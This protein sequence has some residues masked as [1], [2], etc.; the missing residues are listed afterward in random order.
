MAPP[1]AQKATRP[2]VAGTPAPARP[3]AKETPVPVPKPGSMP[4]LPNSAPQTTPVARSL[5]NDA[6]ALAPAPAPGVPAFSV[7]APG[8]AS[9][10]DVT[11]GPLRDGRIR[12]PV[13][14]KLKGKTDGS[15]G[16][17]SVMHMDVGVKGEATERDAQAKRTSESTAL[18]A[19]RA[20]ENGYVALRR[21]RF[22]HI[23]DEP[24]DEP[25][26]PPP[27][28]KPYVPP[29]PPPAVLAT[30]STRRTT[31]NAAETKAEQARLLTL[32]RSLHP[33]L[34]VDQMCKA[35]A[36]FGGIP[37]APPPADGCFPQSAEANGP[38]SL[39]VGWVAEI[40]PKLG[41]NT[42][43]REPSPARQLDGPP[44]P[45]KR[46]RGRPKGS[47]ATKARKDKGIKKGPLK[48]LAT[49]SEPPPP[50]PPPPM[51]GDESWVDVDDTVV[52]G[53]VGGDADD[54]DDANVLLLAR[55][56][57]PSPRQLPT[58]EGASQ[59]AAGQELINQATN[60]VNRA[61]LLGSDAVNSSPAGTKKRGRPKG[62]KNRPRLPD[63]APGESVNSS[64]PPSQVSPPDRAP[65]PVPSALESSQ[66]I[67]GLP[68]FTPTLPTPVK[69]TN[70]VKGVSSRQP[71]GAVVEAPRMRETPVPVPVPNGQ[72]GYTQPVA[73]QQPAHRPP[74]VSAMPGIQ[75]P[76]APRATSPGQDN[77]SLTAQKRKRNGEKEPT[78]APSGGSITSS[79]VVP[80]SPGNQTARATLGYSKVQNP[81]PAKRQKKAP[82]VKAPPEQSNAYFLEP[83]E[84]PAAVHENNTPSITPSSRPGPTQNLEA[85]R[86]PEPPQRQPSPPPDPAMASPQSPHH[87]HFEVQSPTMENYEAQ[88]QAQLE[89]Q[90]ESVAQPVSTQNHVNT[91]QLAS[92]RMQQQQRQQMSTQNR[93]PNPPVPQSTSSQSASPMLAQQQTRTLQT[94][95][96][97]YR[98]GNNQY[99]LQHQQQ[100]QQQNYASSQSQPTQLQSPFAA[101]KQVTQA[102]AQPTQ[103]QQYTPK[104]QQQ[105]QPYTSSQQSYSTAQQYS[106]NQHQLASQQQ[107]QQQQQ[108][109]QQQLAGTTSTSTVSYTAHQSPQFNPS[110][111]PAFPPAD[112]SYRP[113][114]QTRNVASYPSQ[115][116]QSS[117]PN[118]AS[119]YRTTNVSG[120]SAGQQQQGLAHNTSSF[121][122]TTSARQQQR[123]AATANQ[124]MQSMANSFAAAGANATDWS[125]FD[126]GSLDNGQAGLGMNNGNYSMGGSAGGRA[127]SNGGGA[128]FSSSS[129]GGYEASGLPYGQ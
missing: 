9:L 110:T 1:S 72:R 95:Y 22:V 8:D 10:Q 128:R 100:Q 69:K 12:N 34:V 89:Q 28:P 4:S 30:V 114:S 92:A 96:S 24:G 25:P 18:A 3:S 41:G 62:S 52:G 124:G 44:V 93:S 107:Q 27:V 55:E 87:G 70:P 86:V 37:G 56:T 83:V 63:D 53:P 49:V 101:P 46:G 64:A 104:P 13:P 19:Q 21:S 60:A 105:K 71:P 42:S 116:S 77:T 82:D 112:A 57:D 85:T 113:S 68:V 88:L 94:P 103:K 2:P 79:T 80:P 39:F 50:P 40:F 102:S 65:Q 26:P 35:L 118:S 32:L 45:V 121:A 73:S 15:Q 91:A 115:R 23:P 74:P 48:R 14:S 119:A 61:A 38:G 17:F 33:V 51:Q 125:M 122:P 109:Y 29:P 97:Q 76:S 58:L 54:A 120:S 106:N 66:D 47:K 43:Q 126:A 31:L 36:F 59:Q 123:S 81:P 111:N 98:P 6:P 20:Y 129:L 5:S 84:A 78:T 11:S 108:R 127:A 99:A 16:N 7:L 90:T 67:D 117:T 75:P